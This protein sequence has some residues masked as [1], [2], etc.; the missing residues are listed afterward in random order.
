[1]RTLRQPGSAHPS[2]IDTVQGEAQELRYTLTPGLTLTDA[3]TA[4]LIAAG[5]QSA[6][7]VIKNA[8]LAPFRFVMP[9]PPD[10]PA[11]V[12]YFSATVEPVGPV[13]IEQA[14]AT[15]GWSSKTPVIHVHAAW[16]EADGRRR[17]GHIIPNETIIAEP[18]DVIAWGF[19]DI[20]V[21]TVPDPETN[22]TLL[23]PILQPGTG[24]ALYARL[25]PNQDVISSLEK[26]TQ[27]AGISNAVVR[28]SLGS[29]VGASFIDEPGFDDLATEVFV[30]EGFVR[31]GEA[32]VS[33][34]AVDFQ[35]RVRSGWI[36]RNENAVCI[37]FDVVVTPLS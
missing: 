3:V 10:S 21:E 31:N 7:V 32:S 33:L 20:R 6:A 37:T 12:A 5:F 36:K 29:L 34:T 24:S 27:G 17:G 14:N 22:F 11:H 4:P 35:G 23:Q 28:G 13:R 18:T 16:T 30:R 9:G 8:V 2:R 19:R 26:I 1:M 15:F 25:K